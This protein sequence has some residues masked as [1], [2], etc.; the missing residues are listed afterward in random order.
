MDSEIRS[1]V[2]CY[3]SSSQYNPENDQDPEKI[4][5][6]YNITSLFKYN[7]ITDEWFQDN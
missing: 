4:K 7:Y 6:N 3:T 5:Q 2:Y 1:E